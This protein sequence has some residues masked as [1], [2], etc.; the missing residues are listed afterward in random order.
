[1][2][3]D[4]WREGGLGQLRDDGGGYAKDRKEWRALVRMQMI[5]VRTVI[6]AGSCWGECWIL[7]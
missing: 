2:M 3:L 5:E 4:G 6:F 1:M 7:I